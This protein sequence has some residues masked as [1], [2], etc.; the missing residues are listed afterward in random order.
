VVVGGSYGL[1]SILQMWELKIVVLKRGISGVHA[2]VDKKPLPNPQQLIFEQVKGLQSQTADL[3]QR[4]G[5]AEAE[6]RQIEARMEELAREIE[7]NDRE[8]EE[9]RAADEAESQQRLRRE[10]RLDVE[11]GIERLR[12][13][14]AQRVEQREARLLSEAKEL[15]D[16]LEQERGQAREKEDRLT[17]ALAALAGEVEAMRA[18]EAQER[19]RV[20]CLVA[21]LREEMEERERE[22][23]QREQALREEIER[24]QALMKGGDEAKQAQSELDVAKVVAGLQAENDR[25]RKELVRRVHDD[26]ER[27][28]QALVAHLRAEWE[29]ETRA[30]VQRLR[31]DWERERA[32]EHE[33]LA[34]RA[35]EEREEKQRELA[36]RERREERSLV[37]QESGKAL[38]EVLETVAKLQSHL[39]ASEKK[40]ERQ[41][42]AL[43]LLDK[44]VKA[45]AVAPPSAS[46]S[47]AV[48]PPP[49]PP[50]TVVTPA[51]ALPIIAKPAASKRP[52]LKRYP[53]RPGPGCVVGL[54]VRVLTCVRTVGRG[55]HRD[56]REDQSC[57]NLLLAG[58]QKRFSA[59][60]QSQAEELEEADDASWQY[61]P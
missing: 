60:Q 22:R 20:E 29:R 37:Q 56:C 35:R 18:R 53:L 50:P 55:R 34:R 25:Q 16:A 30:T 13:E 41:A 6:Q 3:G 58:L 15:R 48:T 52:A 38:R 45:A 17:S 8:R 23:T 28:K 21:V 31:E 12:G 11:G 4:V 57:A 46:S 9:A 19:Q 39:E 61:T 43:E 49:P 44:R 47:S 42:K 26:W 32:K 7:K 14:L 27:E 51:A 59:I 36:E 2:T 33:A 10:W 54:C 40:V 24:A 5:H 1:G